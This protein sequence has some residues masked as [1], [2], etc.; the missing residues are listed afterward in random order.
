M[1]VEP[2]Q[3]QPMGV[4][5]ACEVDDIVMVS[6]RQR[7]QY[8]GCKAKVLAVLT[9]DCK[10]EMLEGPTVGSTDR[11]KKFKFNQVTKVIVEEPT[12]EQKKKE[13]PHRSTKDAMSLLE[14][15]KAT[16]ED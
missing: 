16:A 3:P 14:L 9:A 2:P 12:A 11:V 5:P 15:F 6:A 13:V 4:A 8:H 10:V 7:A 1:G